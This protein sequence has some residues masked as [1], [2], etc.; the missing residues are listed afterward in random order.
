MVGIITVKLYGQ[1]M[2]TV[3]VKAA[4]SPGVATEIR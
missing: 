1:T 4:L 3:S 2:V